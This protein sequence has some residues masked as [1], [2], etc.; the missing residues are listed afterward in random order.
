MIFFSDLL[1]Q[2]KSYSIALH[3]AISAENYIL[4]LSIEERRFQIIENLNLLPMSP[5]ERS[6]L[7]VITQQILK[8]EIAHR[9]F[10]LQEKD[11]A[12]QELTS[13]ITKKKAKNAYNSKNKRK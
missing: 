4:A 9:S 11:K 6:L 7:T 2:L 5:D 8:E 10:V 13:L 3:E 12:E 1:Q